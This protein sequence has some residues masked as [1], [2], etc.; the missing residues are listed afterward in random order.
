MTH[1]TIPRTL[2]LVLLVATSMVAVPALGAAQV[3]TQDADLAIEQPTYITE[4]IHVE[5]SDGTP[6]YVVQSQSV[7]VKPTNFNTEDVVG[8]GVDTDVG[9][10]SYDE[11]FDR[12]TFDAG[13]NKGTFTLYWEVVEEREIAVEANNTTTTEVREVRTRYEARLRVASNESY[14]HLPESRLEEIREDADIGEAVRTAIRDIVGGDAD[15]EQ[16]T[17]VALNLLRLRHN[18]LEALAGGYFGFWIY[19]VL[20]GVGALLGTLT[21]LGFHFGIRWTDIKY[22][23]HHESLK[24]SELEIDEKLTEM[25]L[26]ERLRKIA[27]LDWNDLYDDYAARKMREWAETPKDAIMKLVALGRDETLLDYYVRAMGHCDYQGAVRYGDARTDGGADTDDNPE[28]V[29]AWLVPP[30][31]DVPDEAD[32][33][34]ALDKDEDPDEDDGRYEAFLAAVDRQDPELRDF[35]LRTADFTPGDIAVEADPLD[36]EDLMSEVGARQL[37]W[38]HPEEWG[39]LFLEFVEFVYQH[40]FTDDQGAP[41][42]VDLMMNELLDVFDLLS[43]RFEL[44]W[45]KFESQAIARALDEHDP[46]TQAEDLVDDVEAGKYA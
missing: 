41:Q 6:T 1:P 16:Q 19:L 36:I 18:P 33:T 14:A 26:E 17:Q 45:F 37:E 9:R 2:P 7:R 32:E 30:D 42:Q 20:G 46:V 24:A 31:G 28:I 12:F 35:D 39:R 38:E 22:R 40:D 44:P 29:E 4:D 5:Q 27:K 8:F 3:A 43:D 13:G 10:L 25:E 15:V 23:R 21:L 34:V 11:A